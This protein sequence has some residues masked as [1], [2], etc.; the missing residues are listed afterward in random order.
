[1]VPSW[2]NP[3]PPT[4]R[5]FGGHIKGKMQVHLDPPVA[6]YLCSCCPDLSTNKAFGRYFDIEADDVRGIY[7]DT[8][9]AIRIDN[10]LVTKNE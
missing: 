8:A 4:E 9:K 6:G 2:I 5:R 3:V 1:M 7:K 10:G